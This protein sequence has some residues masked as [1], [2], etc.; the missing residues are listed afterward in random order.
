MSTADK[1]ELE[2]QR[3]T[4]TCPTGGASAPWSRSPHRPFPFPTCRLVDFG[5]WLDEGYRVP[6]DERGDVS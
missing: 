1:A 2:P 3:R 5:V 4:V 6:S